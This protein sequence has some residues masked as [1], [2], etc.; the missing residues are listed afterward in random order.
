MN[1][2]TYL[3]FTTIIM[4]SSICEHLH[5]SGRS[6]KSSAGNT[7]LPQNHPLI[8]F[9]TASDTVCFLV[10]HQ[11]LA[12]FTTVSNSQLVLFLSIVLRN[13]FWLHNCTISP[14]SA[15]YPSMAE[16]IIFVMLSSDTGNKVLLRYLIQ[17][18]P[19]TTLCFEVCFFP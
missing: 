17:K 6:I 7:L 16:D 1:L 18:L 15:S 8:L 14:V 10:S 2:I 5:P 9:F 4:N 11:V 19:I 12:I 3:L 13:I